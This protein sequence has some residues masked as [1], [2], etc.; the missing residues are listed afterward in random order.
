[1]GTFQGQKAADVRG[2][3]EA[4]KLNRAFCVGGDYEMNIQSKGE[5]LEKAQEVRYSKINHLIQY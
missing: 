5:R 3:A 2:L 4:V 1:M